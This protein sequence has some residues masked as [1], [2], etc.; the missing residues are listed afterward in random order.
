MRDSLHLKIEVP[1]PKSKINSIEKSFPA[2]VCDDQTRSLNSDKS[3]EFNEEAN[4]EYNFMTI[5]T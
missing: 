3:P 5:E 1:E 2:L 4:S